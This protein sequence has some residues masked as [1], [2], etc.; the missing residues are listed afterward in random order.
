VFL[1]IDPLRGSPSEEQCR[2]ESRRRYG[3]MT[4]A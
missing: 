1:A 2:Q 3:A 4:A